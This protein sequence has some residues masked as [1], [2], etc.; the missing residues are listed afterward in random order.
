MLI[1]LKPSHGITQGQI[2][3]TQNEYEVSHQKRPFS[4]KTLLSGKITLIRNN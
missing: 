3:P 1:N 2:T 4:S